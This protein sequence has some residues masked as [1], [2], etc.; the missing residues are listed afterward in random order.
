MQ[1]SH[2]LNAKFVAA[3]SGLAKIDKERHN[4]I[5]SNVTPVIEEITKMLAEADLPSV[6]RNFLKSQLGDLQHYSKVPFVFSDK[7]S[8]L[9]V[10]AEKARLAAAEKQTIEFP[11]GNSAKSFENM[12]IERYEDIQGRFEARLAGLKYQVSQGERVDPLLQP[13]LDRVCNIY[14][15][16]VSKRSG[17]LTMTVVASALLQGRRDLHGHVLVS[18]LDKDG[19]VLVPSTNWESYGRFDRSQ[20][21]VLTEYYFD[22]RFTESADDNKGEVVPELRYRNLYSRAAVIEE[23]SRLLDPDLVE[24]YIASQGPGGSYLLHQAV[25]A[26]CKGEA[27]KAVTPDQIFSELKS[28]VRDRIL[29]QDNLNAPSIW[30]KIP[31]LSKIV[32]VSMV[33]SS[34]LGEP[35]VSVD[36]GILLFNLSNVLSASH[37]GIIK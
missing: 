33:S 22:S 28:D 27:T 17:P 11:V 18:I 12:Q 15:T 34:V 1:D 35:F 6:D 10:A 30:F 21:P 9:A 8:L 31:S 26:V 7:P 5:A 13:F 20:N 14:D 25:R 23:F 19:M 2:D 37:P 4:F 32:E 36:G 3:W 29:V 24:E 16:H